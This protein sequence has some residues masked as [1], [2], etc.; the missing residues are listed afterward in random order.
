M[1]CTTEKTVIFRLPFRISG[2]N[3]PVPAGVYRLDIDEE[4]L[5]SLSFRAYRWVQT[6]MHLRTE[7]GQLGLGHSLTVDPSELNAALE[8]YQ[9]STDQPDDGHGIGTRTTNDLGSRGDTADRQAR[10]RTATRARNR[11]TSSRMGKCFA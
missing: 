3:D 10:R 7:P 9:S 4:L 1:I 2:V 8:L 11:V 6:V 5:E